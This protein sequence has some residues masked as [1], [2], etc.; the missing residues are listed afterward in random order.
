M[1][2]ILFILVVF[3]SS[4]VYGQS[5]F[6]L[7]STSNSDVGAKIVGVSQTGRGLTLTGVN[8]T[9]TNYDLDID[10][11]GS[12]IMRILSTGGVILPRGTTSQ[13]PA[14]LLTEGMERFNSDF[15]GKELFD[16]TNW[17][18]LSGTWTTAGRPTGMGAG[19]TGFN[20]T[21]S[22]KEYWNGTTWIQF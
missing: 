12:K 5:G 13:R 14:L 16:G 3:F 7:Y 20:T 1:K 15:T 2:N 4:I 10:L 18:I 17:V 8:S 21:L 11:A 9:N 22:Q 19:S 6:N